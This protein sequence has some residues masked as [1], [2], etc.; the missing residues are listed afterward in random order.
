MTMKKHE[1]IDSVAEESGFTRVQVRTLLDSVSR[2]VHDAVNAGG[3]V[4]LAGLGKLSVSHRGPRKARDLHKRIA[5][6]VP[7]RYVIL[8]RPSESLKAAANAEA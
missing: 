8:F 1:L 6:I 3:D 2:V 4:F 7:P 5:V